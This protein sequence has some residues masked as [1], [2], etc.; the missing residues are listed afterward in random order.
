MS[1]NVFWADKKV[2]KVFDELSSLIQ[3]RVENE[4]RNLSLNPRPQGTKKL[5][6]KLEG[7]W[8]LRIGDFRLLYE[9]D[10]KSKKVILLDLGHRRQ[11]YR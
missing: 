10:D 8:R 5:S 7:I 6:G 1:Y 9:I 11:I 2:K 3:S 4:I